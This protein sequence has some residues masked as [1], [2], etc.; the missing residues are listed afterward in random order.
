VIRCPNGT[1]KACFFQK[2]HTPGLE[3]VDLVRLKE[4]G[5]HNANYLVANSAEAVM[6]LVQFNSLEFHPWGAHADDPDHA[7][8]IVFDL[9]PGPGVPWAEVKRSALQVR[10]LLKKLKLK[11]YLRTT[12]GK[13]LHVVL[14][15]NPVV[16]WEKV[17]RFAK[18]FAD[19]LAT[20][21][22]TRFVSSA[23]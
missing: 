15:L 5:G 4:E 18:G 3:Q 17:K 1:G 2:H 14:P 8:R 12:G 19:S 10:D 11:S 7:D 13:G 16:E 22:P 20:S 9:D 23:R 21:E 6:E